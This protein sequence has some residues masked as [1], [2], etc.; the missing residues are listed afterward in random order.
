MVSKSS[1]LR[2][3]SQYENIPLSQILLIQDHLKNKNPDG[4]R[5][6]LKKPNLSDTSALA[7]ARLANQYI[8]LL[9][10]PSSSEIKNISKKYN[11]VLS[12][13]YN[14]NLR[15]AGNYKQIVPTINIDSIMA[16]GGILGY[17]KN[18]VLQSIITNF[19]LNIFLS[20]ILD[21]EKYTSGIYKQYGLGKI[22]V[23][24]FCSSRD[25]HDTTQILST[26]RMYISNC[27]TTIIAFI[28]RIMNTYI[29]ESYFYY[30]D[31]DYITLDSIDKVIIEYYK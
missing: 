4:I 12:N 9:Q 29:S 11:V 13:N 30:R 7:Q 1:T 5:T 17:N 10:K 21:V 2:V 27:S 19:Q 14:Q 18:H 28:E 31:G 3:F 23:F 16:C 24:V 22:R 6:I 26:E 8:K 15:L 20:N 25:I